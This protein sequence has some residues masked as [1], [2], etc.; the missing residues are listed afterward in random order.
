V[1]LIT[2]LHLAPRLKKCRAIPVFHLWPVL[3]RNFPLPLPLSSST[4][5]P[6][7]CSALWCTAHS[8]LFSS[9]D[10]CLKALNH[11]IP[12]IL[13]QFFMGVRLPK[14]MRR[15]RNNRMFS[16]NCRHLKNLLE[17]W[18]NRSISVS[19]ILKTSARNYSNLEYDSVTVSE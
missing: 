17:I 10:L 13:V 8:I 2:R 19:R 7:F 11:V 18:N 12:R 16:L 14:K 6:I 9:D 15:K 5:F 1:S 4:Y 3:G